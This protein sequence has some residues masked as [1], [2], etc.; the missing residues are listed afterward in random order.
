MTV[1]K[2]PQVTQIPQVTLTL[3]YIDSSEFIVG[4]FSDIADAEIWINAEKLKPNWVS[5][6]TWIIK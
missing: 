6:T 4:G 5:T 2:D 3:T 1:L